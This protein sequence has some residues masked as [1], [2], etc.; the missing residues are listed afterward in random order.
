MKSFPL[1]NWLCPWVECR[2]QYNTE[3]YKALANILVHRKHDSIGDLVIH[4]VLFMVDVGC[5]KSNTVVCLLLI[6]KF[7]IFITGHTV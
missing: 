4:K 5:D 6:V 7:H 2:R 1:P 3:I